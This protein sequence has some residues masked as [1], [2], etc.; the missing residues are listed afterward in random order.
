MP[1]SLMFYEAGI[2]RYFED[3]YNYIS[4]TAGTGKYPDVGNI[5]P[6]DLLVTAKQSIGGNVSGQ[7]GVTECLYLRWG[8]GYAKIAY[9]FEIN[10]YTWDGKIGLLWRF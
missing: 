5:I 2:T 7:F 6:Q 3:H 1:N 10:R 4:L 9:P 8:V